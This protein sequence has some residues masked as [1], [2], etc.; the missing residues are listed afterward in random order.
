MIKLEMIKSEGYRKIFSPF[1]E[2]N[3]FVTM[4]IIRFL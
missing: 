2:L 3:K 1:F 4:L